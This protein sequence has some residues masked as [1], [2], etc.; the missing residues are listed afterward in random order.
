MTCCITS[1]AGVIPATTQKKPDTFVN[2][3]GFAHP[4]ET[5]DYDRN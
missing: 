4:T 1:S 3:M 5:T 2:M